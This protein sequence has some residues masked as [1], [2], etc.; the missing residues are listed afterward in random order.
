[1]RQ[2]AA[3]GL[4]VVFAAGCGKKPDPAP[5]ASPAPQTPGANAPGSPGAPPSERDKL[6]AAVR[7]RRG[8]PQ[9]D[10]AD[11]LAELADKD[12]AALDALVELL[13]DKTT[14]GAGKTSPG[15]V[16][17]VREAAAV[18]LLRAGPK[19]EAA[20]K[21]KGLTALREG[22]KD[23][24]AAVREHTAY[25]LGVL[26]RLAKPAAAAVLGLC[27]DPDPL[28]RD[29]AFD[30]VTA[31]GSPDVPALAALL[32]HSNGDVRRRAAEVVGVLPQIP[33][34]AAPSL[35]LA[36]LSDDQ[37]VRQAAA[38]GLA[39]ARLK[40]PPA[41]TAENL[42]AAI[43]KGYPDQPPDEED[44][45]RLDGPEAAYW[46]AL[47]KCGKA[48]VTP[49]AE[50]L[51]HPNLVVRTLAARTLADLGPEAKA[52][53]PALDRALNDPSANVSLEVACTL[54]RLGERSE[55]VTGLVKAALASTSPGV[56]AA[57]VRAIGQ[58]GPA[59]AALAPLAVEKLGS[60]QADARHAAVG[61]V[62]KLPPAEG[63]K[64]L[65]TLTRLVAD[66]EGW[67][68]RRV[69][70]VLEGWGPAAS[71]AAEAVG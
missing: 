15:V 21:D 27:S 40:D 35:T 41:K 18:A 52:A 58:M 34:G 55:A 45:V 39:A 8:D 67:V 6:V 60:L 46:R 12:P 51:T 9:R 16:G 11:K 50:L 43:R 4:V 14:A 44:E 38:S 10:A 61:F 63:V 62:G 22:L 68:R 33:P 13:R 25:T 28:V 26:G 42:A 65:P 37:E 69:G 53:V 47:A 56:A 29:A 70:R 24:D 2:L 23:R 5:A 66:R 49:T 20:L 59:G 17:S 3:A 71:P 1:M 36:L 54:T 57:A 64:H 48:G 19:G 30:A 32:N 31:I 7:A